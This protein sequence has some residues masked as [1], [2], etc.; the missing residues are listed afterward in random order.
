LGKGSYFSTLK[1][2]LKPNIA[3]QKTKKKT[4]NK[5]NNNNNKKHIFS[6]FFGHI[7]IGNLTISNPKKYGD[8]CK[9]TNL[10]RKYPTDYLN[11]MDV[12]S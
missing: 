11:G 10:P 2:T 8:H 7:K 5:K 12:G 6:I 9:F 4:K 1:N 3:K